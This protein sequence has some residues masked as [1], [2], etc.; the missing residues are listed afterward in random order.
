MIADILDTQD[1]SSFLRTAR[2]YAN[3]LDSHIY[4]RARSHICAGET[5]VLEWAAKRNKASVIRKLLRKTNDAPIP[6]EVKNK[7]LCRAA[8]AGMHHIIEILA[9]AGAD[10]SSPIFMGWGS[11]SSPL[12]LAAENGHETTALVLLRL[13]ADI[14]ATNSYQETALHYAAG[15]SLRTTPP[16]GKEAVVRLLLERGADVA[17]LTEGG[18]AVLHHATLSKSETIV[19]MILE[20][21]VDLEVISVAGRTPLFWALGCVYDVENYD[22]QAAILNLLLAAG[23]N[24]NVS[25]P[26]EHNTPLHYAAKNGNEWAVRLLLA[27]G[28][29][30]E[31]CDVFGHTALHFAATSGNEAVVRMLLEK[32]ADIS[33]FS[34]EEDET[35]RNYAKARGHEEIVRILD[36]AAAQRV[37]SSA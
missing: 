36:E 11:T 16:G 9:D 29:N 28:A 30:V 37:K 35:P 1:V 10:I 6:P 13:G 5:P 23:A 12:Q 20:K 25:E 32:G 24:V 17:A 22:K 4:Q 14:H 34:V 15:G 3:I 21:G 31:N 18:E 19:K 2:R 27:Y 8:E 7:A 26:Y 33:V